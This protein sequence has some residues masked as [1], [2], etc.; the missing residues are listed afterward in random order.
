[1]YFLVQKTSLSL[2]S[3]ISVSLPNLPPPPCTLTLLLSILLY[4][5][6]SSSPFFSSGSSLLLSFYP[7][8]PTPSIPSLL[9]P[10][11]QLL[12]QPPKRAVAIPHRPQ[13]L[14]SDL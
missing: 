3:A 5:I 10:L 12:F 1:M 13:S 2:S 14:P 9:K 6:R 11:G 4:I 8:T 7:P